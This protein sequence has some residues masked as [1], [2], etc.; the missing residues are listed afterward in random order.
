MP[1]T[2]T[3]QLYKNFPGTFADG[4]TQHVRKRTES[5]RTASK[6]DDSG[7]F[8]SFVFDFNLK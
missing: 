8:I 2:V 3:R 5:Y 4:V 1:L 6:E 7:E